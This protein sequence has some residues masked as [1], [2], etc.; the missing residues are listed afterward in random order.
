MSA[1]IIQQSTDSIVVQR[2]RD[3]RKC[4]AWIEATEAWGQVTQI[5][6]VGNPEIRLRDHRAFRA[7]LPGVCPQS[8]F[9]LPGWETWIATVDGIRFLALDRDWR[10]AAREQLQALRLPYAGNVGYRAGTVAELI[11]VMPG[12]VA[13][14]L[15]PLAAYF[16]SDGLPLSSIDD[17]QRHLRETDDPAASVV[18]IVPAGK[19][20]EAEQVLL[21]Q[22]KEAR[23]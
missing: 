2:A 16:E 12:D 21:G 8:R 19:A 9:V 23:S 1:N 6:V 10:I 13:E 11:D 20:A 3:L 4:L 15:A 18:V 5:D 17:L 7:L 22:W 14:W